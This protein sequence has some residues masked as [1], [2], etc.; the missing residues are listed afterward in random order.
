MT[1]CMAPT[2]TSIPPPASSRPSTISSE[3]S[4]KVP[5]VVNPYG[6]R[7]SELSRACLH[8][9][10]THRPTAYALYVETGREMEIWRKKVEGS[11]RWQKE[12]DWIMDFILAMS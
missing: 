1:R 9:D 12:G 7:L 11:I 3:S 4:R 2:A 5:N 10:G 6:D 8:E